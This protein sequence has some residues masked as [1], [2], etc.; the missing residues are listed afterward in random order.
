LSSDKTAVEEDKEMGNSVLLAFLSYAV[1]AT[2]VPASEGHAASPTIT[3][4]SPTE[5]EMVSRVVSIKFTVANLRLEPMSVPVKTDGVVEG[6]IHVKVDNSPWIWVHDTAEPITIA[7]MPPGQHTVKLELA[8]RDHKG[9][10][11]KT[12]TFTVGETTPVAAK[13]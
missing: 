5:G 1:L 12:V 11:A 8:G 7:G 2:A 13:P 10:D 6:H 3:I 4:D 9:L